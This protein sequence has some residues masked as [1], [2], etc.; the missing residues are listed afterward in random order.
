M[1]GK[2]KLL[3]WLGNTVFDL[4]D[5]V[6]KIKHP[7]WKQYYHGSPIAFNIKS[8]YMGTPKDMGLHV[9]DRYKVAWNHF[10]LDNSVR[11]RNAY[12]L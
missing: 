8:P 11:G 4:G 5:V 3:K 6:A 12:C 2:N 9:S 10:A 1:G 7:T